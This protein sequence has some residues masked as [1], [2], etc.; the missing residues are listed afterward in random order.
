[1]TNLTLP[2]S[3]RPGSL[4]TSHQ[5]GALLQVNP[6]SINNWVRDGRLEAFRTP[7]GHRRIRAG[8]LVRFLQTHEMP[9]PTQLEAIKRQRVLWVDGN[10]T[11]RERVIEGLAAAAERLDVAFADDAVAALVKIGSFQPQLVVVSIDVTGADAFEVTRRLRAH[12]DTRTLEI[13]LVASAMTSEIRDKS[14]SCGAS[15]AAAPEVAVQALVS[16][17]AIVS[18]DP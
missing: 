10:A 7:G 17:T 2:D 6:S 8:D 12:P 3:I 13:G 14:I 16:G 9:I 11:L 18:A 15:W 1:M 4:L 5:A